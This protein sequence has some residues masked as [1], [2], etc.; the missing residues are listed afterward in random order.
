M[1]HIDINLG[2]ILANLDLDERGGLA[3]YENVIGAHVE[4]LSISLWGYQI[5]PNF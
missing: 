1:A 4:Q 2:S 3:I 5:K